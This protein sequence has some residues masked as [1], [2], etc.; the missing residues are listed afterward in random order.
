MDDVIAE[1]MEEGDHSGTAEAV[2]ND[3]GSLSLDGEVTLAELRDD[4]GLAFTNPEVTTVAGLVLAA[5]GTVP[6]VGSP[7]SGRGPR[8]DRRGRAG[9]QDHPGPGAAARSLTGP[10]TRG[11]SGTSDGMRTNAVHRSLVLVAALALAA[12]PAAASRRRRRRPAGETFQGIRGAAPVALQA[13]RT[14]DAVL[15]DFQAFAPDV[16]ADQLFGFG[17]VAVEEGFAAGGD[18]ATSEERDGR[19]P[20]AGAMPDSAQRSAA[21]AA[22]EADGSPRRTPTPRRPASTSPTS[23]RP[24]VTSSTSSTRTPRAHLVILDGATAEVLQ[25]HPLASYGASCCSRAT[26]CWP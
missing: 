24:T 9:P 1:V 11:G 6:A 7:V 12:P 18:A 26:A 25:P 20:S 15:E 5:H 14:C 13:D 4:H 10:G 3:D 16:L 19:R 23:S 22:A 21:P 2:R 8:A 17:D